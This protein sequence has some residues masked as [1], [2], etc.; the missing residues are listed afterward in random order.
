MTLVEVKRPK[1]DR[2]CPDLT[3]G[4]GAFAGCLQEAATSKGV[5]LSDECQAQLTEMQAR[6][7]AWQQACEMKRAGPIQIEPYSRSF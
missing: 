3:P 4:P 7:A 6:L 1:R 2:R 5:T